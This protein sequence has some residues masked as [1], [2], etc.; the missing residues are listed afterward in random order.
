MKD[1][2]REIKEKEFK[3]SIDRMAESKKN[4]DIIDIE[5][6]LDLRNLKLTQ[7]ILKTLSKI[8]TYNAKVYKDRYKIKKNNKLKL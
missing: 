1:S 2:K 8:Q 3:F 4:K 5:Y 6:Y 7:Y